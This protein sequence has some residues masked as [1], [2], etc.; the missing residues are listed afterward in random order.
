MAS[1]ARSAEQELER[2]VEG[3]DVDAIIGRLKSSIEEAGLLKELNSTTKELHT[4]IAKLGKAL[5]KS[6]DMD[7]DV[8]RALRPCPA[9]ASEPGLLARVLAE[10]FYREGRFELGDCLAA[11]A[12]LMD[13]EQLRAPYA[14][15]HEVLEQIRAR[16]LA[17][18]L[19]WAESQRAALSPEGGPSAF[20][21]RLHSLNFVHTLQT[22]GRSAALSYARRHF[23]PHAG[24]G[25][26]PAIQ[27]LMGCLVFADRE[28]QRKRD[29]E[30]Q[31]RGEGEGGAAAGGGPQLPQPYA[32]LMS[33]GCWDAAASEFARLACSLMGQASESPLSTVV[34]A[35]AVAL[36]ALLKLAA[37]M[38]RN[39]QDL[40]AV[41]QLPVEIEL[42]P[43]FVFRSI[44][45]CPVSRDA[46]GPDN[47]P[48]LLP[49]GHVLCEQSVAKLAAKSRV[50][51]PFK[52]P[53]CPMEARQEGL[54]R[55][56]FPEVD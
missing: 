34:A 38:E 15:M 32:E 44:F 25:Q 50:G 49:C 29:R 51:R 4:S 37:V 21:F 28:V 26:L 2:A 42:G 55:L 17:P 12:G 43:R 5:E 19:Q 14:S 56:T 7:A 20:E 35:G 45:A 31:E 27:R 46:S 10:H 24:R 47:P 3:T 9:A 53:Y 36:P 52:C 1:M 39:A 41:E 18:A 54:R 16:N 22:Q 30:Q 13:A 11:E 23:A 48:L 33:P 8:C 6:C 40:R